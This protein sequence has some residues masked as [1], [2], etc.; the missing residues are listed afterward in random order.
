MLTIKGEKRQESEQKETNYYISERSYGSLQRSFA[1]PEGVDTDKV[2]AHFAKGVLTLT[3]PK[4]PAAQQT[5][6]KIEVKPAA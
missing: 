4:T 6:K 2:A 1:V 3:L 5:Q